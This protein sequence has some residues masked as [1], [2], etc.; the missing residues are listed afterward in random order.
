MG[1]NFF[2]G[3]LDI[4]KK[5]STCQQLHSN[6]VYSTQRFSWVS[7]RMGMKVVRSSTIHTSDTLKIAALESVLMATTK[8][9]PRMPE[10]CWM[11][12]DIPQAMK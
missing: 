9:A 4:A 1:E 5:L 6:D 11:A 12:P 3:G 8:P 7:M 2:V 10:T